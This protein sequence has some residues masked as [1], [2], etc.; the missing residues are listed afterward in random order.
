MSC[1]YLRPVVAKQGS[2]FLGPRQGTISSYAAWTSPRSARIAAMFTLVTELVLR[3]PLARCK[4]RG[5]GWNF[6]GLHVS[7]ICYADDII[8]VSDRK[9]DLQGM[10]SEVISGFAAVGLEVGTDKSHWFSYPL[11]KLEKLRFGDDKVMWKASLIFLCTILD[12][13]GNDALAIDYRVAQANKVFWKWRPILQCRN[14]SLAR[15]IDLTT[16]T[17]FAAALW[18]S[19]TWYPT[20]RQRRRL[21][22]W[23]A[24]I[25]SQVAG[26]R[27]TDDEDLGDF[28]CRMYRTGHNK[29]AEHGGSSDIRRRKRLHSF[30]GHLARQS[31]LANDALRTRSLSWWRHFQKSKLVFH[32]RRFAVWRW[33][34]QLV[35]RYGETSQLFVDVLTGWMQTAQVRTTWRAG[36]RTFAETLLA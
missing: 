31:S 34:A 30:A 2:R 32:P 29:L 5:S 10:I 7:A 15:R 3:A 16:K 19:E 36:E 11:R 4:E 20:K 14:A 9:I 33:E 12:F 18:L 35:E 6:S 22:S 27:K 17:V 8:L 26:V 23:A 24:R 1:D 25:I 28:W 13:N 21:N